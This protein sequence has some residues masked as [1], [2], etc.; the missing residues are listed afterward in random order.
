MIEE[1]LV[2]SSQSV[3]KE[4]YNFVDCVIMIM[5]KIYNPG[6]GWFSDLY[7]IDHIV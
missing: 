1:R 3:F 4:F 2:G 7:D 5:L 6:L